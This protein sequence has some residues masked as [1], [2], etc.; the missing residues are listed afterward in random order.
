MTKTDATTV[1]PAMDVTRRRLL[2]A[3]AASPF[4]LTPLAARSNTVV[5]LEWED[6]IPEESRGVLMQRLRDMSGIVDHTRT[7]TDNGFIQPEARAVTDAYNGQTVRLPGYVVPLDFDSTG[8]DI[9]ILAPFIGACIHVPP[10]PPNQLV[11]VTTD[12]PYEYGDLW[13]PVWVTGVFSA[14]ATGTG[15]AEIG[16]AMSANEIEPYDY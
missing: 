1:S 8:I 13:D 9:F 10:P 2:T 15:L 16:Y 3:L 14:A 12:E 11:L 7:P 4:L 5:D 6:L